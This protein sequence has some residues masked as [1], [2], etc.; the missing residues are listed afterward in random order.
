MH[1]SV[2]ARRAKP[3]DRRRPCGD[4]GKRFPHIIGFTWASA[5]TF[6]RSLGFRSGYEI[7]LTKASFVQKEHPGQSAKPRVSACRPCR[8]HREPPPPG[9]CQPFPE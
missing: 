7:I 1:L 2:V 3:D 5:D 6:R 8:C 4:N 9:S